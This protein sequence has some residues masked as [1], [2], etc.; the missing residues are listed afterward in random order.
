M[1]AANAFTPCPGQA[2][3][4]ASLTVNPYDG[5]RHRYVYC[6][7]PL[8]RHITRD[9]FDAGASGYRDYLKK[10]WKDAAHHQADGI[11]E[12]VN[13]GYQALASNL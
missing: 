5:C 13:R 11:I 10:L 7:V 4:Y 6:Y 2:G 9:R 1:L 3:E 12:N 8:V